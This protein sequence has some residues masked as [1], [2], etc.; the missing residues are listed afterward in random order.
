MIIRLTSFRINS[1]YCI[2]PQ[3]K[4]ARNISV[5]FFVFLF[6]SHVMSATTN[7]FQHLYDLIGLQDD[8]D[9]IRFV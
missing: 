4:L 9:S 2:A 1:I 3:I 5:R 8:Y 7:S 6:N